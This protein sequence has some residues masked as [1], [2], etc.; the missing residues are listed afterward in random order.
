MSIEPDNPLWST[1]KF[2]AELSADRDNKLIELADA[3][4]ELLLQVDDGPR[5]CYGTDS[6]GTD[7]WKGSFLARIERLRALVNTSQ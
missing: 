2:H 6:G 4:R 1:V 5:F 3:V 7:V